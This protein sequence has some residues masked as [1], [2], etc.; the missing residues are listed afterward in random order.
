MS[1][2]ND[3]VAILHHEVSAARHEVALVEPSAPLMTMAGWRF[4]SAAVGDDQTREAGD[5]IDFFVERDAF[6]QVLE[7][8]RA[9]D[10]GE[11]GEG[12]R[13]PLG[14]CLAERDRGAVFHLELGAVDDLVAF[15]LA[16]TIVDDGDRTRAVHGNQVAV[17]GADGDHV[18]EAHDAV[19]LGVEVRLLGDARCGTT[20]VEGT[21]GELRAR[22]ADGLRSDD[23]DCFAQLDQSARGEVTAVAEDADATLG[24][25]GEHGADLDALNAG[26]L[27]GR[28]EVFVDLLV[29][30]DDDLTLEVL[31]A[32][33]RDA[34]DDAVAQRLDDL[35]GLDDRRDVDAFDRAA[36]VL[37]DD[38]VLRHVDETT[39]QVAGV[40]G[41]QCGIGQALTRAVGRDEV[42]QHGEA[43]TEVRRDGRLDDFAGRL[44][45]Q[46][47]HAG[48]LTDLL[49]RSASAGVGHDVD[50][51]HGARLV[52]VLH[53]VEH[54]VGNALGDRR[55]DLDDLVVALAVGDRA[56]KILLLHGDGLLFRFADDG[57]TSTPG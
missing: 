12:V 50:R 42:L 43:F 16:A 49:L 26:S 41:L 14:Q 28:G 4:S 2:G 25:A 3:L 29:D 18:D 15:L 5:F 52:G 9:A 34:A 51:V 8:D 53:V 35:A 13:I 30:L 31:E 1:P 39:G 44:G 23:A 37:A 32:L 24:L 33:E 17:L 21:H 11:D 54:L 56:V 36:I 48:E 6:L 20:D 40:S 47:A 57:C 46:A 55:P 7:L 45:H 38:D 22:L 10:L 27:D 19:V